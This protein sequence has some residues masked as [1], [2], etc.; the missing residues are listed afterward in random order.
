MGPMASYSSHSVNQ[1]D[2]H[3]RAGGAES[4]KELWVPD[5]LTD[6]AKQSANGS[7]LAYLGLPTLPQVEAGEA[8]CQLFILTCIQMLS[9]LGSTHKTPAAPFFIIPLNT[10]LAATPP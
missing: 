8:Q 5:E 3:F 10:L 2:S 9:S 6:H 4:Y 7:L 1:M